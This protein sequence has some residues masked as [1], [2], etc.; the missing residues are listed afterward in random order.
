MQTAEVVLGYVR[1]LAW[2]A[3]V[4]LALGLFRSSI[5][6]AL[7]RLSRLEGFGA[8]ASLETVAHDA[9]RVA[10]SPE[11]PPHPPLAPGLDPSEMHVFTLGRYEDVREPVTHFREGQI[12]LVD[13]GF[14]GDADAKRAVD[15][16]AGAVLNGRGTL[17]RWGDRAFLLVPRDQPLPAHAPPE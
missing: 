16:L 2:P 1:A 17:L 6:S 15:F 3:V 9:Q 12:V 13:L 10:D 7:G 11:A 8:K 4:L 14:A 5:R